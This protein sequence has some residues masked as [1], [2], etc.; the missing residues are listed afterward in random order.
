MSLWRLFKDKKTPEEIKAIRDARQV[1]YAGI[2]TA[3]DGIIQ[4]S[5]LSFLTPETAA[6]M[7]KL[8]MTDKQWLKDNP[9]ADLEDIGSR[10]ETLVNNLS[11][12][13]DNDKIRVFFLNYLKLAE[14]NSKLAKQTNQLT[15]EQYNSIKDLIKSENDWYA[16]NKVSASEIDYNTE[17]QSFNE[18]V[19]DIGLHPDQVKDIQE[20]SEKSQSEVKEKI[21]EDTKQIQKTD[22]ST[23]TY[24]KAGRTIG[25][26][27]FNIVFN[28]LFLV[29]RILAGCLAANMAIGRMPIYRLLYFLYGIIPF[30]APIV[31]LYTLYRRIR[32]G[33]VHIYAILP[34][35]LEPAT[36]RI[37]R[38]L[39]YPFYWIP[40]QMSMN[41]YGE[42][43]QGLHSMVAAATPTKTV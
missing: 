13:Q 23:M 10:Y 15:Q 14:N 42:F 26:T 20:S 35:S 6:E 2:K 11:T 31:L 12:L 37:G 38:Y 3:S 9:N 33:P 8:I 30:Y 24:E 4:A 7:S 43:Q 18:K 22:D 39:W 27:A 1:Y 21:L 41:A 34:L 36:T 32:F 25:T 29:L 19:L 17:I 16:K 40:N 5:K 28:W